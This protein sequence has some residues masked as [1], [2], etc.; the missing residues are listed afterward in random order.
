[1]C[2]CIDDCVLCTTRAYVVVSL[3]QFQL[4]SVY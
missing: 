4:A 1:M 2:A 3:F